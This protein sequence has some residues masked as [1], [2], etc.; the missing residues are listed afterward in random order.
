MA[1]LDELINAHEAAAYMG[2]TRTRVY[3]LAR[4]GKI[5]WKVGGFWL[6]T[7]AELDAYKAQRRPQGGRPKEPAGTPTPVIPA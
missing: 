6:Y 7:R 5:G 3:A 1:E 4:A 2:I